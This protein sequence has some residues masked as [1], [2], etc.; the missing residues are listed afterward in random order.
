MRRRLVH[1]T[2]A[3]AVLA[4][5]LFG[6]PLA[7][8]IGQYAEAN[9]LRDLERI[10]EATALAI[11]ADAFHGHV[12]G[13]LPDQAD[14]A[15]L[16]LYD[17][18][19]AL[20]LGSGPPQPGPHVQQAMTAEVSVGEAAEALVVAVPV[21]HD[22]DVIGVVRAATPALAVDRIVWLAWLVRWPRTLPG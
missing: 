1:L 9:E 21:T 8:A 18:N 11:A 5:G 7:V 4:V 15:E 6:L 12:L 13:G 19:G 10:A 22:G 3:A 2:V 20:I 14:D 17:E 16:A